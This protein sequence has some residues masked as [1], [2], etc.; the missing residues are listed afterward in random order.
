MIK[1][2]TFPAAAALLMSLLISCGSPQSDEENITPQ[3]I[4]PG[5]ANDSEQI[6]DSDNTIVPADSIINSLQILIDREYRDYDILNI[7]LD[8]DETEEQI[9]LASPLNEDKNVF[10]IYIADF[11]EKK[12][13]YYE[14]YRSDIGT[15][16]LNI[17]SIECDDLTGDHLNEIIITGI[18]TK[19]QQILEVFKLFPEKDSQSYTVKKVFN[20]AVDGDFE[21]IRMDRG[22]DYKIDGLTGESFGLEVQKKNPDDEKNLIVERFK[23]N[24]EKKYYELSNSEK[25]RISSLSNEN[26]LNFYRGTSED[27]LD[28]LKG[29]W[30]KTKDLNGNATHNMNEIFQIIPEEKTITFY[31]G[32]IQES[33]TWNE[34][35]E[36]VKYRQIL[37]FFS[38][39]NNF[40]TSMSFSI[41]ISI[42]SFETIQVKIR[43]NQRWGGTY[44]QLTENLQKALTDNSRENLLL[45]EM[46]VKGLY[47][48]NLNTEILFDSPEYILKEDDK[49]TRG[50]FTIFDLEGQQILEMKELSSNGLTRDIK[51]YLMEYS[52]SADD[53][54]IIRTIT[55][56]KGVLRARGIAPESGSELHFEQIEKVDQETTENP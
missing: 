20:Q 26:L 22:N 34:N 2:G 52:E 24:A 33:F 49:E 40:L 8:E 19:D 16:N 11:D 5:L 35:T 53:L 28:F 51:T 10:R 31:S 1:N 12:D 29:P 14:L 48:T 36:P 47:K 37:S 27:Y 45:S 4:I 30:F 3:T 13:E 7:N 6:P 44:S 46:K 23:W 55:L 25:V 43:G 32:D 50:I 21:I 54:R 9:I 18:D 41:S 17:A 38:V 39:R 15:Y 56:K 42:D